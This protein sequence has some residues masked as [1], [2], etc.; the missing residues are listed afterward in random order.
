MSEYVQLQRH[1]AGTA[2]AK[3]GRFAAGCGLKRRPR[4]PR[5][6]ADESWIN[7]CQNPGTLDLRTVPRSSRV[8]SWRAHGIPFTWPKHL[9]KHSA[10]ALQFLLMSLL[11]VGCSNICGASGLPDCAP[12]PDPTLVNDFLLQNCSGWTNPV[13]G[14]KPLQVIKCELHSSSASRFDFYQVEASEQICDSPPPLV[15]A[16]PLRYEGN[17]GDSGDNFVWVW[18]LGQFVGSLFWVVGISLAQWLAVVLAWLVLVV[19]LGAFAGAW[20]WL[21]KALGKALSNLT[22]RY[23]SEQYRG[24]S[25]TLEQDSLGEDASKFEAD[26][27]LTSPTLPP[28]GWRIVSSVLRLLWGAGAVLIGVALVLASVLSIFFVMIAPI[29]A[30]KGYICY[31]HY[32]PVTQE[33]APV[34]LPNPDQAGL[35]QYLFPQ[36]GTNLTLC[37]TQNLQYYV[38]CSKQSCDQLGEPYGTRLPVGERVKSFWAAPASCPSRYGPFDTEE[39]MATGIAFTVILFLVVFLVT[40][41]LCTRAT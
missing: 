14:G 23:T 30:I 2:L 11:L 21:R 15:K 7:C 4:P 5:A 18:Y 20:F 9:R 8:D 3:S 36:F 6:T 29:I 1:G 37:Q 25:A 22:T 19:L 17:Y 34:S 33:G 27:S 28:L 26:M 16:A 41:S 24:A 38:A 35:N 13:L 40:L 12:L 10:M 39:L 32:G 31:N